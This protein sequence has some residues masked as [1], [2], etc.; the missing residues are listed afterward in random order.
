MEF[1]GEWGNNYLLLGSVKR[2]LETVA[3]RLQQIFSWIPVQQVR[4]P[5]QELPEV[6]Q[7]SAAD[8][9]EAT[10]AVVMTKNCMLKVDEVN[11]K[12]IIDCELEWLCEELGRLLMMKVSLKW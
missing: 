4:V 6:R 10:T 9:R 1:C 12:D 5:E 2:M 3:P 7:M 8:A 11:L